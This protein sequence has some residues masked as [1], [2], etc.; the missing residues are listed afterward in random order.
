MFQLFID[1]KCIAVLV[2][3]FEDRLKTIIYSSRALKEKLIE[4]NLDVDKTLELIHEVLR[5]DFTKGKP[6]NFELEGEKRFVV[7]LDFVPE[8]FVH[9]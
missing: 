1:N 3:L 9:L 2:N 7:T 4:E 6:C 5:K 8:Y